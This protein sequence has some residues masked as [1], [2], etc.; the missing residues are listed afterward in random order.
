MIL[1]YMNGGLGNQL[2][3]YMFFRWLEHETGQECII[4]DGLFFGQTVPHNGYELGRIFGVRPQLLSE[5]MPQDVWQFM[6]EQREKE[7]RGIAQQLLDSGMPLSVIRERG[8]TNISFNGKIV[9]YSLGEAWPCIS[10]D[11]CYVHGYWLGDVCYKAAGDLFRQEL[12]FPP[13]I[14]EQNRQYAAQI[15]DCRCPVAVHVRRGDMAVWGWSCEAEFFGAAVQRAVQEFP[16]DR[17]FLFS[18][19]LDW[20]RVHQEELGLK[21]GIPVMEVSGNM[22][23]QAFRDLQLMSLCQG[24]I[25]DR[26]SFSLLAGILC[27]VPGKWEI[28][29][30]R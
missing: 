14:E 21:A 16:V 27:R 18:D 11:D 24:R 22:G 19:D 12:A 5:R 6:T 28:N 3:Q 26:S 10:G 1:V 17:L 20:C 7:G 15:R 9:D 30:W 13:I 23:G 2:F 29:H 25:S 8:V 4:D